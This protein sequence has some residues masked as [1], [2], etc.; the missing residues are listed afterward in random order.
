MPDDKLA[1]LEGG[2]KAKDDAAE[3]IVAKGSAGVSDGFR[4][5]ITGLMLALCGL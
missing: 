5:G 1:A 3:M 4:G 2:G